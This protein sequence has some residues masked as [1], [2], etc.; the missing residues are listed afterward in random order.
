MARLSVIRW[1]ESSALALPTASD[2]FTNYSNALVHSFFNFERRATYSVQRDLKFNLTG[3]ATDPTTHSLHNYEDEIRLDS[4]VIQY[5]P[6]LTTGTDKFY[7]VFFSDSSVLPFPL[8][9]LNV[10]VWYYDE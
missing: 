4:A 6:S 2:L 10:R 3:T 7:V 8:L 5:D 1:K 9:E